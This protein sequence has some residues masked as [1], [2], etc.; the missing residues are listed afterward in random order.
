MGVFLA[1]GTRICLFRPLFAGGPGA[2]T[3]QSLLLLLLLTSFVCPHLCVMCAVEYANSNFCS[4]PRSCWGWSARTQFIESLA[5][6]PYDCESHRLPPLVHPFSIALKSR[7]FRRI[8][9]SRPALPFRVCLFADKFPHT[10]PGRC[11]L[12]I[13]LTRLENQVFSVG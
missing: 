1:L 4:R 2:G 9:H 3:A 12:P 5:S 13:I 6:F 11:I 8:I 7:R 10:L